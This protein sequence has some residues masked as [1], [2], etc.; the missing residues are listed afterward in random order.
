MRKKCYRYFGGLMRSQAKW[1]NKMSASGYRLVRTGKVL[2]EFEVCEP[3]EYQYCV[4]FIGAKARS[5]A[6]DYRQFLED[7]GYRVLFK[8][9][10]LHWSVGKV[11]GRPW[12]EPGG[13]LATSSTTLDKELLIIEKRNDGR[14]F[15][16]YTTNEDRIYNTRQMQK[17]WFYSFLLFMG[18]SLFMKHWFWGIFSVLYLIPTVLYQIEIGRLQKEANTKEW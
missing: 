18:C 6:E 4:E 14:P 12:A 7:L 11:N 1:L 10:N 2:Y 15:E 3:N 17:P 9:I 5:G 16:L 13:R 8:N